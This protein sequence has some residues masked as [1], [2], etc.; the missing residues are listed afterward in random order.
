MKQSVKKFFFQQ[1]VLEFYIVK[2]KLMFLSNIYKII[3]D[4]LPHEY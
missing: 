1:T 3:S 4:G 2:N